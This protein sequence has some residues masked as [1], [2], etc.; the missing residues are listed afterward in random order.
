MRAHASDAPPLVLGAGL[1]VLSGVNREDLQLLRTVFEALTGAA[2]PG[3]DAI[4][5]V[6]GTRMALDTAFPRLHG[7]QG[8]TPPIVD[9]PAGT[10]PAV[11]AGPGGAAQ[12][13]LTELR[14]LIRALDSDLELTRR[15]VDRQR[16]LDPGE[17]DEGDGSRDA[18]G[19][20]TP[21]H[22]ADVA[23]I[24]DR[25]RDLLAREVPSDAT[26]LADALDEARRRRVYRVHREDALGQLMSECRAAISSARDYLDSVAG[27][28]DSGH[29]SGPAGGE[30]SDAS[31]KARL[32]A[33][34]LEAH[35]IARLD[36]LEEL[37]QFWEARLEELRRETVDENDLLAQ[38]N[39]LL[40]AAG[41]LPSGSPRDAAVRLRELAASDGGDQGAI[42]ELAGS[43]AAHLGLDASS[44]TAEELVAR[45]EQRLATGAD[46]GAG[47]TDGRGQPH[48]RQRDQRRLDELE[49]AERRLA[50]RLAT[51]SSELEAL[52]RG[53]AAAPNPFDRGLEGPS[54]L[55]HSANAPSW[56]FSA[57]I[58]AARTIPGVGALPVLLVEPATQRHGLSDVDP[59]AVA[60]MGLG[61]QV[62]WVTERPEVL[63]GLVALGDDVSFISG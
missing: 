30:D 38:A 16:D 53:I 2:A 17:V 31:M 1:N 23:G 13:R 39:G 14:A 4:V 58:H 44:M 45:A 48:W 21:L 34:A 29:G 22:P 50:A 56:S 26:R 42:D 54:G 19:A 55:T 11:S 46:P 52:E 40:I 7:L 12:A 18:A 35:T 41:E 5:E 27:N 57:A 8:H 24:C 10:G 61:G 49:A 9:V 6:D 37:A 28:D 60:S 62:V 59:M 15:E 43:L 20:G 3:L 25:L 32:D 51:A 47:S 36:L 63:D 33:G